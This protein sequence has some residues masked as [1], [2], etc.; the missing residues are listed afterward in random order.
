MTLPAGFLTRLGQG[1]EE[2]LP[3]NVVQENG[4]APIPVTHDM[5]KGTGKLDS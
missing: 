1:F 4:F 3:V 5:V 2:V